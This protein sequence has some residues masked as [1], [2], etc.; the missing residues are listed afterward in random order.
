MR[1][2]KMMAA[3]ALPLAAMA[4]GPALAQANTVTE[5]RCLLLAGIP[6][7]NDPKLQQ[8]PLMMAF[9]YL[10]RL[11]KNMTAAELE[12]R[13]LA[14]QKNVTPEQ[15][16]A[17]VKSCGDQVANRIQFLSDMG[18]K[19]SAARKPAAATPKEPPKLEVDMA[20]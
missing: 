1:V 13:L 9:Y 17:A 20:E 4:S 6:R 3:A 10:G 8:G 18:P 2:L 14:E 19:L 16:Q 12:Q 15:M 5:L 11:D 7:T